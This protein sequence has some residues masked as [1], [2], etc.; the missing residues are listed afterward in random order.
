MTHSAPSP[1]TRAN[2]HAPT[3]SANKLPPHNGSENDRGATVINI[4]ATN[5]TSVIPPKKTK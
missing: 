3:V 5:T 1:R 4:S 2:C